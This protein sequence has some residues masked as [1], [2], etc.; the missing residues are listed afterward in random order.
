MVT[1]GVVLW[2]AL[3]VVLRFRGLPEGPFGVLG[4]TQTLSY[5]GRPKKAGEKNNAVSWGAMSFFVRGFECI[6]LYNGK[7]KGTRRRNKTGGV[8]KTRSLEGP[9]DVFFVRGFMNG[10]KA[11]QRETNTLSIVVGFPTFIGV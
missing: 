9:P 1:F 11:N 2:S 6:G 4:L 8:K 3:S 5:A 7:S 10:L